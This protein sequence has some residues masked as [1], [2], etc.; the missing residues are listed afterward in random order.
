M[1]RRA[2]SLARGARQARVPQVR[3][4]KPNPANPGGNRGNGGPRGAKTFADLPPN[5]KAMCDKWVKQGL[6]KTREDYV[7]AYDWS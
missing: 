6:I 1:G 5:A 3:R 2:E 4:A 7:K